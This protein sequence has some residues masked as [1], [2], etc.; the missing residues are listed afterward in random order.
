MKP[1]FVSPL[2]V[3]N[4]ESKSVIVYLDKDF[5]EYNEIIGVHPNDNTATIWLNVKDLVKIIE[6]HGNRVHIVKI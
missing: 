6:E 5:W 2:G 4:D 1:G 3:L